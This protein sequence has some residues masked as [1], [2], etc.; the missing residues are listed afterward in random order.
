MLRRTRGGDE[1]GNWLHVTATLMVLN[2][3]DQEK[4]NVN[5]G[6]GLEIFLQIS[7]I[8][9]IVSYRQVWA[10][11]PIVLPESPKHVDISHFSAFATP[12]CL[13]CH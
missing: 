2:D 6:F 10:G 11:K 4:H 5:V 13:G 12:F 3:L 9:P 8:D 1:R 7:S